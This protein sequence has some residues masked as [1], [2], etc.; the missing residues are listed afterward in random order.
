MP[1]IG[2]NLNN[3]SAEKRNQISGKLKINNNLKITT[4]EKEKQTI[5]NSDE[6][7]KFNFK[8]DVSYD[9]DIGN[10][11][12]E[13][14]LLLMEE[15]KKVQQIMTDWKK[16]QKLSKETSTLVFNTILARCNVKAL[17]LA[18]DISLPPHFRLPL[19]RPNQD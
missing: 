14:S 13:G 4:I 17:T 15:P 10:L 12:M 6:V 2:F 19:I 7:L 18:Q 5:T 1:V 16:D 11:N 3:I 9:P 8:F